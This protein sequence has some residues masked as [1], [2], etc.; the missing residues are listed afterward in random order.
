MWR[1]KD[2]THLKYIRERERERIIGERE[3]VRRELLEREGLPDRETER[4][5]VRRERDR[6]VRDRWER[7]RE[8]YIIRVQ[9]FSYLYI[10]FLSVGVWPR[11]GTVP[12]WEPP[13]VWT[14]HHASP[15]MGLV[16]LLCVFHPQTLQ[17][18]IHVLLPILHLLHRMVSLFKLFDVL[19]R[20]ITLFMLICLKFYDTFDV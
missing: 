11:W 8:K 6:S 10:C 16:L 19:Q 12:V 15:R 3:K 18:K 7:E 14:D 5:R 2:Q 1:L 4:D 20:T 9:L 17:V 13:G